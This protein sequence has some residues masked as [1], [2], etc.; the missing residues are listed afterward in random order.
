MELRAAAAQRT[1]ARAQLEDLQARVRDLENRG[2]D[3]DLKTKVAELEARNAVLRT[4]QSDAA[5]ARAE[6]VQRDERIRQLEA[7]VR[8]KD[9]KIQRLEHDLEE[10][11]AWGDA[12]AEDDLKQIRGIGPGFERSLK[13]LGVRKLAQIASWNAEDIERIAA[14]IRTRPERI[15]RDGWVECARRLTGMVVDSG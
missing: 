13:Q 9:A 3:S 6:L 5:S 14:Q 15:V 1:L 12:T 2:V 8:A 11:L 7:A 10:G 4:S